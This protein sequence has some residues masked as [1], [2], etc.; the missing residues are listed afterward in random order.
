MSVKAGQAQSPS[1]RA[2]HRLER[3]FNAI[4]VM[5]AP[6]LFCVLIVPADDTYRNIQQQA[7][8]IH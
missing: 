8:E 3:L 1:V 2:N 5:E 4:A 6:G 7:P